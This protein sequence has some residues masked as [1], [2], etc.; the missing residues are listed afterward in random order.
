LND[1]KDFSAMDIVKM[2][3]QKPEDFN[4]L[5]SNIRSTISSYNQFFKVENERRSNLT[6]VQRMIE[7][8]SDVYPD[9]AEIFDFSNVTLKN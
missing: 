3:M 1:L 6:Y 8:Y 7:N 2:S 5:Q 9:L 4:K